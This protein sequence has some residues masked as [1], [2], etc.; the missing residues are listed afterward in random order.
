[1]ATRGAAFVDTQRRAADFA[2]RQRMIDLQQKSLNEAAQKERQAREREQAK[3][4]YE[5][6]RAF[7]D[8]EK[9]RIQA[10][11]NSYR[12]SGYREDQLASFAQELK[13]VEEERSRLKSP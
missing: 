1:M 10:L 3:R 11:M 2:E 12:K 5:S 8:K 4:D 7:L 9:E 6:R 13:K